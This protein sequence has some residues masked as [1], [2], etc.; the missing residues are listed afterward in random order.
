M[1]T[2]LQKTIAQTERRLAALI[3]ERRLVTHGRCAAAAPYKL[4]SE[5][6]NLR[7]TLVTLMRTRDG[8]TAS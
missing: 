2:S 7:N 6:R 8:I 4:Q 5:I 1:K 3:R